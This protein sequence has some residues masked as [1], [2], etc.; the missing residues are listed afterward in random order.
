[1]SGCPYRNF[2]ECPQHNKKGGCEFWMSYS[3]TSGVTEAAMEG[4]AVVLTPMLLLE[5]ANA[6]GKV[7]GQV[8]GVAAEVSA[9]RAEATRDAEAAETSACRLGHRSHRIDRAG[10]SE[11]WRFPCVS[12]LLLCRPTALLE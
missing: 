8:N 12:M 6:L 11:H 1:M 5:Q 7:A 3:S 10:L 2:D 4:C 9:A